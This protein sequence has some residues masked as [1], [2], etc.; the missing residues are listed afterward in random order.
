MEKLN[1]ILKRINKRSK[2]SENVESYQATI[3]G[4]KDIHDADN[5]VKYWLSVKLD[6]NT[7]RKLFVPQNC[8]QM[9]KGDRV[10]V[11]GYKIRKQG[12]INQSC[13]KIEP[14]DNG[15]DMGQSV[16]TDVQPA[17]PEN[18]TVSNVLPK[19]VDQWKEKYRLTMSNLLSA[20]LQ[21]SSASVVQNDEFDAIDQMVR[22][23]L[24]ASYDGEEAPF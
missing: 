18:K 4:L 23:V 1:N 11:T 8:R 19:H 22:K 5:P 14:V 7:D 24:K 20:A 17:Y 13:I 21:K 9:N 3:Q 2:M 6:N 10:K 16:P 12:S 15:E